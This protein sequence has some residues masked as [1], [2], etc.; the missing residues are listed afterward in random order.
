MGTPAGFVGWLGGRAVAEGRRR[1]SWASRAAE[2]PGGLRALAERREVGWLAL[3]G[4]D[5]PTHP[6]PSYL[7]LPRPSV[8]LWE[9]ARSSRAG[10]QATVT[11]RPPFAAVPLGV[12]LFPWTKRARFRA[13]TSRYGLGRSGWR[14][15]VLF[16]L[17]GFPA[18]PGLCFC[19]TFPLPSLPGVSSSPRPKFALSPK[20]KIDLWTFKNTFYY[21]SVQTVERSRG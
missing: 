14:S 17:G 13:C 11:G 16:Y 1:G 4:W 15:S 9:P 6:F 18:S 3:K 21:G 19:L 20:E 10:R 5:S 8:Y 2:G 12:A 7:P